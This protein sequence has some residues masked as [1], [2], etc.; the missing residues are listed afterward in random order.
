MEH[1]NNTNNN[2]AASVINQ[3][4]AECEGRWSFRIIEHEFRDNE[5]I[6]LGELT[7]NNAVRQQFGQATIAFDTDDTAPPSMAAALGNAADDALI[8][9]AHTF[10]IKESS[11]HHDN[12]ATTVK[13]TAEQTPPKNG[14]GNVERALTSK[15]LA[16]IYG[17]GKSKGHSQQD[18]I[19]LTQ[20]RFGKEPMDLL[21]TEASEIIGDFI[22]NNGKD[23]ES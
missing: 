22:N 3:L 2:A 4:N 11:T 7:I 23:T 12:G 10:G 9:C 8:Q 16:A 21:V 20:E 1:Q 5:I 14:N 18:I 17:L 15:Q 13:Q 6:V 19:Q